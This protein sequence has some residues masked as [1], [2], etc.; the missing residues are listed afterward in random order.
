L[1]RQLALGFRN[2]SSKVVFVVQSFFQEG[3]DFVESCNASQLDELCIRCL[4]I[5]C[6]NGCQLNNLWH[7]YW[8]AKFWK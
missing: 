3:Q 1:E 7:W 4:F 6:L 2:H 5:V 8:A